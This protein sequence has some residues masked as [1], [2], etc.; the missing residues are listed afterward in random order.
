MTMNPGDLIA[1]IDI[2]TSK[3]TTIIGRPDGTGCAQVLGFSYNAS[4]GVH[5][6]VITNLEKACASI[7]KSIDEAENRAGERVRN[8]VVNATINQLGSQNIRASI[9]LN[10]HGVTSQ[11]VRRLKDRIFDEI[12]L[13]GRT[14]LLQTASGYS[15]DETDNINDP[16]G[17]YGD[18]LTMNLHLL[19]AS[20]SPLKNLSTIIDK[21]HLRIADVVPTV[22]A[23]GLSTLVDDEREIGTTVIDMGAGTTSVAVFLGQSIVHARVFPIGGATLSQSIAQTLSIKIK[24]AERIK[25]MLGSL[26]V[27][28]P[29]ADEVIDLP[30]IGEEDEAEV[31]SITKGELN[32]IISP[33][34]SDLFVHIREYL[35]ENDL[36]RI[37]SRR[38]VITGG[39]CQ[40][41][42]LKEMAGEI[43]DKQVRIGTASCLKGLNKHQEN[44]PEMAVIS[45]L[46]KHAM[47][48]RHGGGGTGM[49]KR[50]IKWEKLGRFGEIIAKYF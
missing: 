6:G 12:D 40:L 9:P 7:A 45:G 24:D 47:I 38:A 46:L 10:G 37:S 41:A 2:G 31:Y 17:T 49:Q 30:L 5:N 44:R 14:V 50:L 21:C 28:M 22:Y 23:A 18:K 39:A 20:N 32:E 13:S 27:D 8:V 29:D 43:L 42:G 4:E 36:Y 33:L 26:A 16:R 11:D 25:I 35:E 48:N 3:I 19:Y 34:M 1:A 15:I